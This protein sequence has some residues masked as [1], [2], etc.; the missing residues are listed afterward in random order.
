[1]I[2][3]KFDKRSKWF[4]VIITVIVLAIGTWIYLRSGGSFLP[5]WITVLG[6]A[7]LLLMIMS[8]P[9]GVRLTNKSIEI[10]CLVELTSID[11]DDIVS[12]KILERRDLNPCLP[13]FGVFGFFGYYGVYYSFS[14]KDTFR[15]Y[16][17]RWKNQVLIERNDERFFVISVDDPAEFVRLVGSHIK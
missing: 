13:L 15:M 6:S 3:V 17:K 4:T 16:C 5:A 9:K 7:I 2:K 1:M 14:L 10:H 8:I 11:F 12:I